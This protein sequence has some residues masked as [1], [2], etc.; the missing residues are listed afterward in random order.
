MISIGIVGFGNLGRS[1]ARR[2][3]NHKYLVRAH[4]PNPEKLKMKGVLPMK[5]PRDVY[6]SS[7]VVLLCVKPS[8]IPAVFENI[9][10][11][12]DHLPPVLSAAAAVPIKELESMAPFQPNV[13]RF[14]PNVTD[15]GGAYFMP[16]YVMTDEHNGEKVPDLMHALGIRH[17][18]HSDD[19]IDAATMAAGCAPAVLA[20]F[21][22]RFHTAIGS[23][24][25]C[26]NVSPVQQRLMFYET[27]RGTADWLLRHMEEA[28]NGKGEVEALKEAVCSP[29]GVTERLLKEW[30]PSHTFTQS[31]V[32]A[33][34]WLRKRT[35]DNE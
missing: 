14:M 24:D 9:E 1:V 11:C 34:Q 25:P 6:M 27:M 20:E 22:E 15:E 19:A 18:V 28:E 8:V 21:A 5:S 12:S 13:G 31:V 30:H 23:G 4:D 10:M 3:L 26:D 16:Q 35:R 2:L 32:H 29:G 7:H 33:H 17:R